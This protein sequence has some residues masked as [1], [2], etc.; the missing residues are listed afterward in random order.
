MND[1]EIKEVNLKELQEIYK[2]K[3]K[4]SILIIEFPEN[5][6]MNNEEGETNE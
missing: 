6:P 2:N 4:D 5:L 1:K 3:D